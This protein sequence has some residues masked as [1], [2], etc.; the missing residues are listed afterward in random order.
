MGCYRPPST[1]SILIPSVTWTTSR[2]PRARSIY[3]PPCAT[4]SGSV[5]PTLPC[6]SDLSP[7]QCFLLPHPPGEGFSEAEGFMGGRHAAQRGLSGLRTPLRE[8]RRNAI[9]RSAGILSRQRRRIQA[10]AFPVPTMQPVTHS[11]NHEDRCWHIKIS[12]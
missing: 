12:P 5:A 11:H 9:E 3:A 6:S 8:A 7:K 1:T 10:S 4:P 2:I